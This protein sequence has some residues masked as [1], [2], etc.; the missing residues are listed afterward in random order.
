[1][2]ENYDPCE[3]WYKKSWQLS[4]DCLFEK[5]GFA[6]GDLFDDLCLD[7]EINS[8]MPNPKELLKLVIIEFLLPKIDQEIVLLTANGTHNPVRVDGEFKGQFFEVEVSVTGE[9]IFEMLDRQD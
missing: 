9:Q 8:W 4:S 5:N 2:I 1:M 6:D 3:K 7:P